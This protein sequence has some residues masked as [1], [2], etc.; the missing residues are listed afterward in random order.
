MADVTIS[1]EEYFL[2]CKEHARLQVVVEFLKD[3]EIVPSKVI[4]KMLGVKENKNS[5]ESEDK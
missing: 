1:E 3:E 5:I 2:L 4:L